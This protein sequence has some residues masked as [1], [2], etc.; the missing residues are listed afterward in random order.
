M[1]DGQLLQRVGT[2]FT[3]RDGR[4]DATFTAGRILG[5]SLRG[6]LQLDGR[7]ADA[8]VVHFS[9][10]AQDLDL[11]ALAAVAGI[12]RDIRGGK[13]RANVD[14]SGRGTTPHR[15]ASIAIETGKIAG[16]ASGT[17]DFRGE[18]LDLSVQ[19]QIR[20]GV[21]IDVSQFANLVRIRGRFD[22]PT[23][24]IDAAQS[25]K[26]LAVLGVLGATGG[27]I[28]VLGRA[29]IAPAMQ[30]A[31]PCTVAMGNRLSREA[32]PSSQKSPRQTLDAG[33]PSDVGKA[34]GKLFR[35]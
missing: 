9:L 26:E 21:K 7:N 6:Q 27:G 22:N 29:L 24:G 8:P 20:E 31:A 30:A 11:S 32:A 19:P 2:R 15:V 23:V 34:L 28:A 33:L 10:E 12:R 5:G 16:S 4:L 14:I 18:T 35:R 17:L 1:R 13:V 25:A 3:S